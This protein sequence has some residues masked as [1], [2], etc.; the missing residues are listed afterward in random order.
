MNE[1]YMMF[2]MLVLEAMADS[3]QPYKCETCNSV[4]CAVGHMIDTVLGEN[5]QNQVEASL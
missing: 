4:S 5:N 3:G 1:H 2:V